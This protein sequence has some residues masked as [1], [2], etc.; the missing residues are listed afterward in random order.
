MHLKWQNQQM[1]FMHTSSI[2][3]SFKHIPKLN[4][5]NS[6][7]L[8]LYQSNSDHWPVK[9]LTNWIGLY[10]LDG[11]FY[12]EHGWLQI[13]WGGSFNLRIDQN[14]MYIIDLKERLVRMVWW[15]WINTT[16]WKMSRNVLNIL[17]YSWVPWIFL[18]VSK[19]S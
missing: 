7:Q 19:M 15:L 12:M 6:D 4:F 10:S 17:R 8:Q 2:F 13:N 1:H 5:E 16:M 14:A 3:W 11:F 18:K 9:S